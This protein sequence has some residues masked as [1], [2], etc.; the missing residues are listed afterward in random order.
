MPTS[1]T[2]EKLFSAPCSGGTGFDVRSL[3]A[4]Y[5]RYFRLLGPE[6]MLVHCAPNCRRLILHNH[7]KDQGVLV[8]AWPRMR[9]GRKPTK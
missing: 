7:N 2:L 3:G 6:Q 4:T 1:V 5:L 8:M 9:R